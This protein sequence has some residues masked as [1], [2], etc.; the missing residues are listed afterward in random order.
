M[1]GDQ[2]QVAHNFNLG[3][4]FMIDNRLL[5][6]AKLVCGKKAVDVGTDHGYLAVFL[7]E[8]N[9]CDSVIACDVNK[10][11]LESAKK[12]IHLSGVGEKVETILSDGLDNVPA[13]GVTDVIMAGMGGEL[14][15]KLIEKCQWL[16]DKEKN[17]N[18]ILQ[19]M[20]K[21]EI[22]RK[23]LYDNRFIIKKET[24]CSDNRFVYS[25]IQCEFF[26]EEPDYP[27]DDRY[28]HA[29]KVTNDYDDGLIYLKRQAQRLY[30]AGEGMLKSED[31]Q[32]EGKR[33]IEI[34][35]SLLE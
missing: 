2:S 14:I 22:L 8:N 32:K 16:F 1:W 24:A 4:K 35:K 19:P 13:D 34:A 18:L 23:W 33:L 30:T 10:K 15:V 26:E 6:C 21:S 29:G 5:T 11:P 27:C 25:V 17:V 31:K 28:I 20:S 3:N 7:I 9:I 12:T